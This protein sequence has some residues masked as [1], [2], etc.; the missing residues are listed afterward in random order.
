MASANFS[1]PNITATGTVTAGATVYIAD[2]P[3]EG[4]VNYGLFVDAGGVR[5][6]GGIMDANGNELV[7]FGETASAVN[8]ITVTNA[9]TGN[10]PIIG[11]TGGDTN[12]DIKLTPKGTGVV[13]FTNAS[14]ALGAGGA[15]TLGTVGGSGPAATAQNAWMKVEIAGTA[16]YIAFWR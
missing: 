16:S 13:D 1:E 6:D 4:G 2:A 14:V 3:T 5:L 10:P 11:A 7:L 12:I 9:A 15:A 8:E